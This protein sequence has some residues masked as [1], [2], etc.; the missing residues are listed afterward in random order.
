MPS[1]KLNT[2]NTSIKVVNRTENITVKQ[3]GKT[4]PAGDSG[5]GLTA[6]GTTGQ[7]LAKASDAD[8]D[9]EW[10]TNVGGG[11]GLANVVDDVTPQLGG[12][13]DVNGQS[14]VSEN[15]GDINITPN[16]AGVLTLGNGATGNTVINGDLEVDDLYG[17]RFRGTTDSAYLLT[18]EGNFASGE[19]IFRRNGAIDNVINNPYGLQIYSNTAL[20]GSGATY[21]PFVNFATTG[22]LDIQVDTDLNVKLGDA[23]GVNKLSIKDSTNAEVASIDSDGNII[24][25]NLSGS[26]TGDNPGLEN[27]VEDTTPQLGGNLDLNTHSITGAGDLNITGDIIQT[28]AGSNIQHNLEIDLYPKNQTTVGLRVDTD[29]SVIQLSGL[30]TSTIAIGDNVDVTGNIV[31]SGT[32]DGV[33]IAAEQTRLANTSGTNTGDQTNITGNSG[34]TNA[35]K[36]ATTTVDVVGATAPT[37]G[38]VLTATSSTA[39][40]WQTPAGGG[41]QS[42]YTYIIGTGGDYATLNA[43]ATA[44]ATA[45][46]SLFIKT[47][48]TLTANVDLSAFNDIQIT[49]PSNVIITLGAYNLIVGV[50]GRVSKLTVNQTGVGYLQ[51]GGDYGVI[52]GITMNKS[53]AG[54]GIVAFNGIDYVKII[55]NTIISTASQDYYFI[56]TLSGTNNIISNNILEGVS[57]AAFSPFITSSGTGTIINGNTIRNTTGVTNSQAIG[58]SGSYGSITGNTIYGYFTSTIK[59]SGTYNTISGNSVGVLYS[60]AYGV[61]MAST[62]CTTTGNTIFASSTGCLAMYIQSGNQVVTGNNFRGPTASG[63]GVQIDNGDDNN[64]LTGNQIHGWGTGI[65][66]GGS[67]SDNNVIVGNLLH[68]NTTNLTDTGTNTLKVT[69]TNSDPLNNLV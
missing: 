34:T 1:I 43:Y 40:T 58:I 66:I 32:V 16:G 59:I 68:T 21:A 63:T 33:D 47:N 28:G 22:N 62:N 50:R 55:N 51:L 27:L 64:V 52:D 60:N 5:P 42:P 49:G 31:V 20:D 69:A 44:G 12:S 35:L 17:I 46:D 26:N 2:N 10:V 65:N 54:T 36:S 38:Q 6:G 57:S 41:G 4:G 48:Q 45:G 15:N 56:R 3:T 19:L 7:V 30:G 9:S 13:L 23:L 25:T 39:A 8:Y 24:A 61:D 53:A 18:D 67:T 37:T 11:G 14:I 29:T